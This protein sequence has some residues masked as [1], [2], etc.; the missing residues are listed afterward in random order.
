LRGNSPQDHSEL[1]P[2]SELRRQF[3]FPGS[4]SLS[5]MVKARDHGVFERSG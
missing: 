3:R 5:E 2:E 1:A 4:V